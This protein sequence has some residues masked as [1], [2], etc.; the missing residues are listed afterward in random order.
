[1]IKLIN[2]L[3]LINKIELTL[4][5]IFINK[6]EIKMKQRNDK[7]VRVYTYGVCPQE[8]WDQVYTDICKPCKNK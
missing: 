4:K 6:G 5:P 7:L 2:Q 8:Y 3:K 1:M